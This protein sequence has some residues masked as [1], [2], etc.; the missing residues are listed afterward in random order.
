MEVNPLAGMNPV[1]S[2]LPML[3]TAIGVSY[4]D[5]IREIV[6]S[7]ATRSNWKPLELARTA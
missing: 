2:D 7:A 3:A 6:E 5:L 4:T 1:H